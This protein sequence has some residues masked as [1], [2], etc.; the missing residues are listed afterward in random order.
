MVF[1][2]DDYCAKKTKKKGEK[3][4]RKGRKKKKRRIK[5]G[6]KKKKS[7][8]PVTRSYFINTAC[9]MWIFSNSKLNEKASIHSL[10]NT[11]KL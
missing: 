11:H 9:L 8:R 7:K 10:K 4:R 2:Y 1:G 3:K 6:K 5:R